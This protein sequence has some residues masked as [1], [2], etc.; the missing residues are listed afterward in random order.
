MSFILQDCLGVL[1][2]TP[3]FL[4]M[5]ALSGRLI[6]GVLCFPGFAQTRGTVRRAGLSLLVGAAAL[7]VLLDLAGHAGPRAMAALALVLSL[8]GLFAALRSR[9]ADTGDGR[10]M[11]LAATIIVGWT[12]FCI[13]M[14]VD[15]PEG[16]GLRRSMQSAD[17]VKHAAATWAIAQ[18]GSPP[19]NPTFFEPGAKAAYYYFFYNL[20]ATVEL[21]GAPLGVVARQAAWAGVV[22]A[23][24]ALT[25]LSHLVYTRSGAEAALGKP[26]EKPLMTWLLT[27][28][29]TTGL[30]ILPV[31]LIGGLVYHVW[32]VDFEF[33]DT[34]VTSWLNSVLW[35]PHHITGLAAAWIGFLAI[36]GARGGWRDRAGPVVLAGLAFAS[37]AGVS[38]YVAFGAALIAGGFAIWLIIE[39]R[40]ADFWSW[41]ASGVVAVLAALPWL[42]SLVTG[43]PVGAGEAPIAFEIRALPVLDVLLVAEPARS[44][45]R[46]I[47][48]PFAYAIEFGVY[49]LGSVLFWKKAGRRGLEGD[50]ARLLAISVCVSLLVGTFLR[51]TV[52]LN[53]LGWRIML[54]A[55]LATL[56]WCLAALRGGLFHVA[57]PPGKRPMAT[58]LW[59][60]LLLGFAA[61][62]YGV[63][64]MR[65]YTE[66]TAA[67]VAMAPDERAA[68]AWM[69]A[70]LPASTIVEENPD[71]PRAFGYGLYGHF[72][73]S[74]ADHYNG[75]LF[76]STKA[77]IEAR[78][79]DLK[80]LFTNPDLTRED[81]MAIATRASID[82]VVLRATDPIFRAPAAWPSPTDV[83]FSNEG[84][85]VIGIEKKA[86]AEATP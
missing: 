78:I 84:V 32:I 82:V 85:R 56:V 66:E 79:N 68:W 72:R 42:V 16:D 13:V 12:L 50:V 57:P 55:Q 47:A 61:D 24:V 26:P 9:A 1:I 53:D 70:N 46:L 34:Q 3:I 7:P 67:E 58:W 6:A 60:C 33:W 18:S 74:V 38:I 51:S 63:V 86:F 17:H 31:V 62:I 76:G 35:V 4:A 37:C 43:R 28:L 20:T 69:S 8:G 27:L 52:L 41:K 11:A 75:I 73:A 65:R 36:V 15:W 10:E 64:Q 23:G 81:A 40:W 54:F 39:R 29:T 2:A 30:D 59:T 77:A 14:L 71:R 48:A 19:Y 45:G 83:L 44:I 21:L 5:V 22:F 49:L 80:P 25:A